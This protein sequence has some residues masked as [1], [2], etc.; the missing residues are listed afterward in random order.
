MTVA[1]RWLKRRDYRRPE[2]NSLN[3]S[4]SG[5][6]GTCGKGAHHSGHLLSEPFGI[7]PNPKAPRYC[8]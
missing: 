7:Q 6:V 1:D 2:L 4:P 3:N 5:D 8:Y